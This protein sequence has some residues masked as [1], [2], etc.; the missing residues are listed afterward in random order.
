[1]P[2]RPRQPFKRQGYQSGRHSTNALFI[3]DIL[4]I[5]SPIYMFEK[6]HINADCTGICN[7]QSPSG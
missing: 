6:Q 7:F 1:M 2:I 4:A 5:Q 3:A